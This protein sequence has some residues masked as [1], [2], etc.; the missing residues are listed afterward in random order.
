MTLWAGNANSNVLVSY[1]GSN[2][3]RTSIL[4]LLGAATYLTPQAGYHRQ[5]VNMN[6]SVNY[7]GSNNDR[8]AV[9]NSLGAATYLTP[10]VEQ[11]P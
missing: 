5:D 4:T 7:S 8:T 3:D 9:L 1:S 10:L 2:N 6:G 11:L